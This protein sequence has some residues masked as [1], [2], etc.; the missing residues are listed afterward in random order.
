MIEEEANGKDPFLWLKRQSKAQGKLFSSER[1]EMEQIIADVHAIMSD[2]F[3]Y[4]DSASPDKHLTALRRQGKA[5]EHEFNIELVGGIFV[6]GKLD[7]LS[8]TG[9]KKK[10]LRETKTFR[11][12]PTDDHRWRNVQ[13]NL[14]YWACERL[15]IQLDRLCW[16]YIRSKP[17]SV[18]KINKDGKLSL[19]RLDTLPTALSTFAKEQKI[20]QL[21]S[22]M[23]KTA[24][25]NRKN[26]FTRIFTSPRPKTIAFIVKDFT[27]TAIEIAEKHGKVKARTIERHCEWCEFEPLCR[28]ELTGADADFIKRKEYVSRDRQEEPEVQQVG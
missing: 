1:E 2:Y 19:K 26:Y 16:D 5:A 17:P 8:L 12:M 6:T 24:E 25:A 18:P 4:W 9:E 22:L 7:G 28:A 27:E 14:Y 20:K 3:D 11:N 10:C 13:T 21:P 15:G 23:V